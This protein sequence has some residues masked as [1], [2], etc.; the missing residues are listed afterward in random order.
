MWL[1]RLRPRAKPCAYLMAEALAASQAG[2]YATALRLWEPLARAGLARAQNNVGACFAEGLGVPP[3]ST[4]AERWLT[5]AA[6]AGDP[7]GQRNLAAFYFRRAATGAD[8]ARAVDLYR[9]AAEQGDATAQDMLSWMLLE[10]DVGD[11]AEAHRWVMAAA[12]QGVASSM[13]RLGLLY[14][15][16]R[17][18]ERDAVEAAR[19]WRMAAEHGDADGQAMLGAAHFLGNGVARDG[20]TALAYLIRAQRAGSPLAQPFLPAVRAAL[21]SAEVDQAEVSTALPL[22]AIV[23]GED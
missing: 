9:K 14:H 4:L 6:D 5:L 13:T 18:V 20:V 17:G 15:N 22:R 7:V 2:D 21:T 19:W 16:A 1:D 8:H 23:P 10:D 11:A 3:D 12:A